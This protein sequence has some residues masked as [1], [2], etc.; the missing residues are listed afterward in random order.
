M[1]SFARI[2]VAG[3]AVATVLAGTM[4]TAQATEVGALDTDKTISSSH[5][6]MIYHDDGDMFEVCDTKADG[7]G[8]TGYVMRYPTDIMLSVDDGGDSGC[9][10]DGV[11]ITNTSDYM[12]VL[13]W[14]G[15]YSRVASGWFNE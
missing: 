6:K 3:A 11:D 1:K 9:D 5:G 7:H 12:M 15:D 8:V 4:S 10:K 14:N 13:E 2:A